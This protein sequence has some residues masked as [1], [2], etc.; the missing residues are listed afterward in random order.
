MKS[1][2]LILVIVI[3][4]SCA[5]R[6]EP[7]EHEWGEARLLYYEMRFRKDQDDQCW[8]IYIDSKNVTNSIPFDDTTQWIRGAVKKWPIRR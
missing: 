3:F 1:L 6:K 5:T 7:I 2:L 4:Y 8:A